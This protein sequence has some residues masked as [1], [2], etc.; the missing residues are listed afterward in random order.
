MKEEEQ[1]RKSNK[2]IQTQNDPKIFFFLKIS[3][4]LLGKTG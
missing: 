2:K 3:F 4:L 1:L